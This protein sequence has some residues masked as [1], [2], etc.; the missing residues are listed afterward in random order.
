MTSSTFIYKKDYA[1]S[2]LKSF[3]IIECI[4]SF[5]RIGDF[6]KQKKSH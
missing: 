5:L 3:S 6:V 2:K 4:L 1:L